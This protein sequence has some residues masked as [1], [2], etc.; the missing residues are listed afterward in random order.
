MFT[1]KNKHKISQVNLTELRLS[2]FYHQELNA[3]EKSCDIKPL[4]CIPLITQFKVTYVI[5]YTLQEKLI[6]DNI[7][8]I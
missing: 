1:D 3:T 6:P 7:H 8:Q 4:G 5:L 2:Y